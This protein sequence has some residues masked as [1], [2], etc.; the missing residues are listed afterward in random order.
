M[1]KEDVEKTKNITSCCFIFKSLDKNTVKD[2][3]E[4]LNVDTC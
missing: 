1:L 2:S 4:Q 3:C